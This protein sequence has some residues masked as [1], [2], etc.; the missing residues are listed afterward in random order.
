MSGCDR[1]HGLCR[2]QSDPRGDG[3]DCCQEL[4]HEQA[5]DDAWEPEE[6]SLASLMV[7]IRSVAPVHVVTGED[8]SSWLNGPDYLQ[9]LASTIAALAGAPKN[10]WHGHLMNTC[11]HLAVDV[12]RWRTV[13]KEGRRLGGTALGAADIRR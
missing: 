4:L 6:K 5:R 9:V 8:Q 7:S 10:A 11:S 3:A 2:S 12:E 13:M 1:L